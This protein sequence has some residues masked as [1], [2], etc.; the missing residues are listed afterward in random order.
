[1]SREHVALVPT[2]VTEKDRDTLQW[3]EL[4]PA[5]LPWQLLP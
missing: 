1:M 2:S 5:L 3:W 4:P